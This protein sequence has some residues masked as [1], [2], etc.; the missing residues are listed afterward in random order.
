[1]QETPT[2]TKQEISRLAQNSKILFDLLPDMLFI[3]KDDFVIEH[4]NAA[5]ISKLGN[6]K[7]RKCYQGIIGIDNPCDDHV[8]PFSYIKNKESFGQVIERKINDNFYVE[9]SHVPFVG[10]RQDNLLLVVFRD[11]TQK[12]LHELELEQYRENIEKVLLE[13]IA[14]LNQSETE[15]QQLSSEIN[16]LRKETE[17]LSDRSQMIG[18][19]KAIRTLRET[20]YQVA[21]SDATILITGESGTG[22]E[23]V[24]DLVH[25]HSTRAEKRFLKFNCAAVTESLLESDLFGYEKGAFTGAISSKKGKFE[26]ADGGTIFLDEIGDISPKMQSALLRVLQ[27][28]EILK[29]GSNKPISVDVRIIAATNAN[30]ITAV[31]NGRYREDLYYRL[32]VINLH[33]VPLRER[34]EDIVLLATKFLI[35]YRELFNKEVTF[36]PNS[37]VDKLLAY[38]WPGNVRE[39]ESVIQ[40]AVLFSKNGMI[41]PHNLNIDMPKTTST[42]SGTLEPSIENLI[43]RPLKESISLYE[44]EVISAALRKHTGKIDDVSKQ[45]GLAKTTLYEKMKRYGITPKQC[46]GE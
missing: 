16:H 40:R 17:R 41:T 38:N 43:N 26:E 25:K 21:E 5:A 11:I 22:K 37:V 39:L 32:N 23:L 46:R 33:Q 10:Y 24:A 34:K 4:M 36:L 15:R 30:L 42:N 12:K 9:Y 19:S 27:N 44:A 35:K 2:S 14:T 45:L 18:E 3:I 7:G 28:G 8:C 31:N 1:M 20:I 6:Q 13:K 29:I